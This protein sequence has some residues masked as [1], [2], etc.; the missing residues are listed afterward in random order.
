MCLRYSC[1]SC[2]FST[3][4]S[5]KVKRNKEENNLVSKLCLVGKYCSHPVFITSEGWQSLPSRNCVMGQNRLISLILRDAQTSSLGD[6]MMYSN[7]LQT[8][9]RDFQSHKFT[10]VLC[11]PTATH[12][13]YPLVLLNMMARGQE[14]PWQCQLPGRGAG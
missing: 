10:Q 1:P 9:G 11:S 5:G 7:L 2:C 13:R 4:S 3:Q 12:H 14:K 8:T 6:T